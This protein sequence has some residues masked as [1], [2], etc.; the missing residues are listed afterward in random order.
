MSIANGL[1]IPYQLANGSSALDATTAMANY[2]ALLAG[3]NRA[4]LDSGT[5]M[6]AFGSQIHN[7]GAGTASTDAVNVGQL[8]GLPYL[9]IT[10]GTLT[11]SLAAAAGLTA[12]T[13]PSADNS[14]S[15]ATTAFVQAQVTT[16]LA[17]IA[18]SAP[19]GALM[20]FAMQTAPTG[21]LECTG[22]AVSRTTYA[23]LFTAIGVLYG[24]GD[25]SATFNLPDMRG[26]FRRG[27]D[28][29]A[30]VDAGRAFGSLQLDAFASHTHSVPYSTTNQAYSGAGANFF[31]S[32][33][34][35]TGSTGGTETRP[36]NLA[37]L[38]CIKT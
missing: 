24:S 30:G 23:A 12:P 3:L 28:H 21:W 37:V 38:T 27:W 13:M 19:S 4:L 32:G 8:T 14:T 34:S 36:R 31:G 25:G 7:I 17:A 15:A 10:G 1:T 22:A 6:N 26:N 35:A 11:G 29:G 16:L 2:N 18:A 20:D 5:G 9:T 33:S